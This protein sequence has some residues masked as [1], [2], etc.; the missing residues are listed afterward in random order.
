MNIEEMIIE[1][2][3]KDELYKVLLGEGEYK[4]E[5]GCHIG[6]D[7]PTDWGR[8]LRQGIYRIYEK[9]PY[10]NV[11]Q[12]YED[13]IEYLLSTGID[14]IYVGVELVF[15]QIIHE[16]LNSSPFNFNREKFLSEVRYK[17][18]ENKS[19]LVKLKKWQGRGYENGAWGAF[20]RIN[21]ILKEDYNT[22]IL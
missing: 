6:D 4:V 5:P 3:N 12:K 13:A 21:K 9:Y 2:I 14:E 10:L 20:E 8:I 7:A 1:A 19:E 18:V 17:L 22:S 11:Q 16:G 15:C